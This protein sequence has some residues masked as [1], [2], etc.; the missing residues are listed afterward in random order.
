MNA[1]PSSSRR[2]SALFLALVLAGCASTP[3]P[4]PPPLAQMPAAFREAGW[5]PV[6]AV[7]LPAGARWW[8]AFGDPQLDALVE[9]ALQDNPGL[10]VAAARLAQAR[11]VLRAT[12]AQRAPQVGL[13]AGVGRGGQR[14]LGE[15]PATAASVVAGASW[16][17]DLF[18]RLASA[19]NAAALDARSREA[20]LH[21]ARVAV[22]AEVA[23]RY[24]ALR[25]LDDERSLVQQSVAAYCESLQ[26]LERRQ[27]AG[28]VAELDV[29]RLRSE[30]AATEADAIALERQRQQLEHALA[31]LTGVPPSELR[32]AP[33]AWGAALPAVPPGMPSAL[34]V[35][36]PDVLAAQAS[37]GAAQQRIGIAE[38][39]WF[40]SLALTAQGGFASTALSDLLTASARAWSVGALLALPLFDGGRRRAGVE[41][42][43]A[44]FDAAFG[45]Y[46]EQVLVAFRDVEDGLSALRLLDQQARV[47]AQ[48]VDAAVRATTLS[49]TRYRNGF[50]S[51]LELLDARRSE[52]RNR[53]QALQVRAAQF[54]TTVGLIRAL[55]GGW[56][57]GTAVSSAS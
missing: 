3:E 42:A 4:L 38:A 14:A 53:R 25:A 27:A 37:L 57:E 16:E 26:L 21:G 12:D 39:A 19:S 24:F 28:D 18:G 34:L 23:Q 47:N 15:P 6:D 36:R 9:R 49:D 35:R 46:R 17:V 10:H 8:R 52:L 33:G 40:P 45:S 43:R 50:V 7:P 55:G 20:L 13:D 11:A 31:L 48:A 30:A 54:Q 44:E 5:Q 29:A 2:L 56:D 41:S 51:Q 22:Q 1:L 32:I